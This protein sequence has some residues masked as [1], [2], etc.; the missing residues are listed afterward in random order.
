MSWI[1]ACDRLTRD[2]QPFVLVTILEVR[3]SSP[4]DSGTKMVVSKSEI[5]DTIGGGKLEYEVIEHARNLLKKGRKTIQSDRF[6]LSKDLGQCCGGQVSILFEYITHSPFEIV[7]F[8]G[9]HV[10]KALARILA[11]LPYKTHWIDSR[12]NVVS[13]IN[14]STDQFATPIKLMTN[15]DF[16]VE[17]C[18]ASSVYLIMTHSHDLDFQLSEAVISRSDSAFCGLIGSKS[19]SA[20]FKK[21]LKRKGFSNQEID[22][23]ICPIGLNGIT[24]KSPDEIAVSVSAQVMQTISEKNHSLSIESNSLDDN[25]L[26]FSS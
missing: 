11:R 13:E 10:G 26:E 4:R 17:N 20:S 7:L 12:E 3:G 14:Q 16:D 15:P 18:P 25:I 2:N 9:G 21:R 1:T 8:G 22:Q 5:F 23:L 19:K 24:G 6:N